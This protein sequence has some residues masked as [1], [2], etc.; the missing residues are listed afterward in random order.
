MA[1]TS[2]GDVRISMFGEIET[3]WHMEPMMSSLMICV[4]V[5]TVF[6]PVGNT[7]SQR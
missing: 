1:P 6:Q 2:S 7:S 3:V 5:L 4:D